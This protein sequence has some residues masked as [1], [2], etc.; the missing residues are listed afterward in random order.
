MF[1]DTPRSSALER[2]TSI[3]N[4]R[5]YSLFHSQIVESEAIVPRSIDCSDID[6]GF[7]NFYCIVYYISCQSEEIYA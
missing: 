4:F 7:I 5:L 3:R 1:M 6:F 2:L